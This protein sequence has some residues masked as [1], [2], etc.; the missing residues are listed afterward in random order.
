MVT[1]EHS[2]TGTSGSIPPQIARNSAC[3]ICRQGQLRPL[4]TLS[5]NLDSCGFPIDVFEVQAD[6]FTRPQ[7]KPSQ[8][9]QNGIITSPQACASI[10]MAEN[11]SHLCRR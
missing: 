1:D 5:A 3:G 8:Q 4:L 11:C 10:A 2:T 6:D 9:E 7:T